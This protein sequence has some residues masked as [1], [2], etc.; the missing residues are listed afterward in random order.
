[1]KYVRLILLSPISLLYWLFT[2]LRN[3]AYDF[4][5]LKTHQFSVKVISVGNLSTGGTGKTPVVE[6][7]TELLL[8]NQFSVAVLSRGYKRKTRG[9]ILATAETMSKDIGD[10]PYQLKQKFDKVQ[11]AVCEKRVIGINKLIQN[12]PKPDVIIL[13]D[14]FQHRSVSP[15]LN[16]LL[17]DYNKPYYNDWVLPSGNL[18]E[19][20]SNM[21]RADIIVVTKSPPDISE[22]RIKEIRD[23]I[24]PAK[25]QNL[26]FAH[27]EHG[28][29]KP[30][31]I[32]PD[33]QFNDST[34]SDYSVLL[35][36]GI[37]NP[38]PLA[39]FLKSKFKELFSMKFADHYS[40]ALKDFERINKQFSEIIN[41]KKII[42]TTEKD[43]ARIEKTSIEDNFKT[44]PL[45]YIPIKIC[46]YNQED[47]NTFDTKIL[48]YVRKNSGNL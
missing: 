19:A 38:D 12:D 41:P 13:D 4:G 18:R 29:L 9:Y 40:Y 42:I 47:I 14:A 26:Y 8:K 20:C 30:F 35:F 39:Y 46:F 37:S 24:N 36:T 3:K 17:T 45:Y 32:S 16:I 34:C 1:M 33:T 31:I 5:L 25:S 7:L 21:K 23:K 22:K 11:I 6:Y 44:V 28:K 15:G 2:H 43:I 48:N 10:E 27:I